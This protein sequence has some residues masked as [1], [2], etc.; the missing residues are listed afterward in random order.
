MKQKLEQ[1]RIALARLFLKGTGLIL[2]PEAEVRRVHELSTQLEK[3]AL[4]SGALN[5][6][7]RTRA[8]KRIG[9]MTDSLTA[10][11]AGLLPVV[12]EGEPT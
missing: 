5:D 6:P 4:H 1:L 11:A 3:Y 2:A 8:R 7:R 12:K 10:T 9:H